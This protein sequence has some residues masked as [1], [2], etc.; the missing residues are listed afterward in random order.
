MT[1]DALRTEVAM[2]QIEFDALLRSAP[3]G[4][5]HVA[6][7]HETTAPNGKVVWAI[8]RERLLDANGLEIASLLRSPPLCVD[9]GCP[10]RSGLLGG[11]I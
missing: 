11:R 6:E 2:N 7:G 8:T 1:S 4:A 3:Q 9:I 5:T 10:W